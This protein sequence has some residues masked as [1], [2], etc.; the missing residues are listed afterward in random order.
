[1]LVEQLRTRGFGI[2]Q[3]E[4]RIVNIAIDKQPMPE[5]SIHESDWRRFEGTD[6]FESFLVN[7]ALSAREQELELQN[8]QA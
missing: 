3:G 8:P 1:M 2:Q 5:F 6:R 7:Q 4:W